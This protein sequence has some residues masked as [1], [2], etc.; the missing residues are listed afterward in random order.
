MRF[1][2]CKTGNPVAIHNRKRKQRK[3]HLIF[4]SVLNYLLKG[5]K[6]LK[7]MG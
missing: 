4:H 3:H 5:I 1:P 7:R 6:T 2:S